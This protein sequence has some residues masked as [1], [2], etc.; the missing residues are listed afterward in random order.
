[1]DSELKTAHHHSANHRREIMRSEKCGCFYCCT[2]FEPSKIEEWVDD[3]T[4][5]LCPFCGIDSVIGSASLFP[6]TPEFL[7]RMNISWFW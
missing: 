1:M 5:A 7:K 3:E 4:T 2:V 6:I